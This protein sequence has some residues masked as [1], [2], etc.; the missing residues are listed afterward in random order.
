MYFNSQSV[1]I[2]Y[3]K[4]TLI[5]TCILCFSLLA[6]SCKKK[7]QTEKKVTIIT[8]EEKPSAL[9]D[10]IQKVETSI[11]DGDATF[12]NNAVDIDA[13]QMVVSDRGNSSALTTQ[14]GINI[15][16]DNCNFGD[17]LC[18][19]EES[20]GSFRFDTTYVKDGQ[21]HAVLRTYDSTGNCQFRDLL[22]GFKNGKVLIEDAFLYSINSNLSDV[23]VSETMLNFFITNEKPTEEARNMIAVIASCANG[24]YDAMWQILNAQ[25]QG[26][27]MQ[28]PSS[29]Y[30]FYTIGMYE[31]ATDFQGTLESLRTDGA[32][33]R[34]IQ[35]HNLCYAIRNDD[36][37]ATLQCIS[38]LI[39]HT[40]HDPIYNVLYAKVLT[41][42]GRYQDALE[43]YQQAE[44]DME[45]IWDIWKGKL[46]CYKKLGDTEGFNNCLQ[47]GKSLYFLT[48]EEIEEE[49]KKF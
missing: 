21:H 12:L 40:G 37:E 35:Y 33:K 43:A 22:I 27:I 25:K 6:V 39:N 48:E 8:E 2:M 30:Q 1:H 24:N 47:A 10:F 28:F 4:F 46:L 13:L 45:C 16:H 14:D 5:L 23:I 20:G 49:A 44:L 38:E 42:L 31:C 36:A 7:V 26:L 11:H 41:N 17:Y 34:F 19:I 9:K 15:L 3:K 32:D 29:F 18:D